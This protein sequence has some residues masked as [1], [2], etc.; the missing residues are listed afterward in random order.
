MCNVLLPPGV[1]PTAVKK[2]IKYVNIYKYILREGTQPLYV[3]LRIPL[4]IFRPAVAMHLLRQ[5]F[6]VSLVP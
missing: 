3:F 6:A 1:N 5:A 2:Y 4:H